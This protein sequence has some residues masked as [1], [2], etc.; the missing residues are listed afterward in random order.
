MKTPAYKGKTIRR[1]KCKSGIFGK[2]HRLRLSYENVYEFLWYADQYGLAKKLGYST[3]RGAW[4]ANPVV[5]Y[6]VNVGDYRKVC[7]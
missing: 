3:A 6:S 7:A 4:K 2:R 1:V 5:E